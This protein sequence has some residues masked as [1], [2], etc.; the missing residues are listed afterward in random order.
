MR[1]SRGGPCTHK[2]IRE[3]V[4]LKK[5]ATSGK[6]GGLIIEW[7]QNNLGKIRSKVLDSAPEA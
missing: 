5:E 6:G 1:P 4:C 3:K 7:L 2:N